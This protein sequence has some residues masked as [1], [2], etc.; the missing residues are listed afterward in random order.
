MA[1]EKKRKPAMIDGT[2]IA[3]SLED[4]PIKALKDFEIHRN[5]YHRVIKCGDDLSDIPREYLPNLK[6]EGVID[7]V[8]E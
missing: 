3:P 7:P 4:G 2:S 8:K 1:N 6:A 5:D